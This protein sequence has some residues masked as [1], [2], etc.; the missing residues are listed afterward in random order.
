VRGRDLFLAVLAISW[1]RG[2]AMADESSHPRLSALLHTGWASPED[3][4]PA[5]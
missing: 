5:Q 3:N 1:V 4:S 2:A